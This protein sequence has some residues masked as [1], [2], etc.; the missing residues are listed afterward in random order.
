MRRL[1]DRPRQVSTEATARGAPG[2][3]P[4]LDELHEGVVD[5]RA[6][7]QEEARARAQLVEEEQLLLLPAG[8]SSAATKGNAAERTLV[9]G[10]MRPG[11]ASVP[12]R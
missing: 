10:A 8:E 6:V 3:R 11:A 9:T 2:L 1:P 5:A 12:G 4:D 7:G